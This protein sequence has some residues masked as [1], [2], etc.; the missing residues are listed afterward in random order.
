MAELSTFEAA[1]Y[2]GLTYRTMRGY[3]AKGIFTP[4]GMRSEGRGRRVNLFAKKDL[5]AYRPAK[6]RPRKGRAHG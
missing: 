4:V 1:E 6:R 2:L 5:D 3:V